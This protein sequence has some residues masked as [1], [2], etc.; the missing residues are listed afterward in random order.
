MIPSNEIPDYA[1]AVAAKVRRRLLPWLVIGWFVAYIDRFNV[2]FAGLQ[3]NEDL[4]LSAAVFGFGAGVFFVGYS[5]F[6][7]PSM[8]LMVRVGVRRWLFRIMVTWGL[9]SSAMMFTQGP[10]SFYV[11]RFILGVAE[12]GCF[13]AMAFYLS[14]W[15]APRERAAALG[16]LGSVAMF[17]GI[18]GAPL[19]SALMALDGIGGL[20]GWKWLFLLEG[21]P[22]IILGACLLRYLPDSP[23]EVSWLTVDERSWL[24]INAIGDVARR[25]SLRGLSTVASDA[26]YW[27]WGLAFFCANASGSA[28]R[29]FQ[30]TLLQRVTGLNDFWAAALSGVPAIA[31]AAAIIYVG[32]RA[33]RVDERQWHAAVPLFLA[34]VGVFL[35]G[36]TYG[37]VGALFVAALANVGAAAQ[38]PLF[39][40]VSS[41]ASGPI[42]AVGIAFVNSIAA[43]GAFIGPYLV[44]Y[45][46]DAGIGLP[47]AC[48]GAAIVMAVGGLI[49]LSV[50]Q[51]GARAAL[52]QTV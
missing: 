11:L 9:V 41:A 25:P 17:S 8:L 32:H 16:L 29:V 40:S 31:G 47:M 30:P 24:R 37:L 52:G 34:S 1:D 43:L 27:M 35:V 51:Q 15:L 7:I 4:G 42:N 33:T 5:L 18:L 28:L 46:F 2:S 22:A 12:A 21:I 19:A 45:A 44:G 39:A 49:A 3:M 48:G 26:R 6:E 38:P 13:P 14:Q 10:T 50:R 36:I 23:D 20:A